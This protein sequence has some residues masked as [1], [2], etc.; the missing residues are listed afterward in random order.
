MRYYLSCSC[1]LSCSM[2]ARYR[3]GMKPILSL[4]NILHCTVLYSGSKHV[5]STAGSVLLRTE[6]FPGQPASHNCRVG[7]LPAT[8]IAGVTAVVTAG[9]VQ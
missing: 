8:E 3:A 1:S 5:L 9:T 6:L 2:V 7:S 4:A